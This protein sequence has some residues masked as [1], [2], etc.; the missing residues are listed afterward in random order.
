MQAKEKSGLASL[1]RP[2]LA[3]Y[4]PDKLAVAFEGLDMTADA[5]LFA[6]CTGRQRQEYACN[7]MGIRTTY[8]QLNKEIDRVARALM[9]FG[10][11]QGDYVSL[12]LPNLKESLLY[13][14]ACWRI[15]AI[16]NLIDPRTHGRGIAERVNLTKSKLLVTVMNVCDP[17]IDEVLG[18]LP[19]VVVVSPS[20]SLKPC[21]HLKATLG[22]FLFNAKKKKFAEGR[23]D[24]GK[25]VW[26]T[27]FIKKY[28]YGGDIRAQYLPGMVAAVMY[29]SGTSSDGIIKGAVHTHAGINA[30][31]RAYKCSGM[32]SEHNRGLTFGG[33]IPF[34]AAYGV[35]CGMHTSLCAGAEIILIPVFD[36]NKFADMVLKYK[37]NIFMGVP[38]FFEQIA[39]HP[40]L[41]KPN[42][43]L[44]FVR[45]PASGGDKI[46]PASLEKINQA[47]ARSGYTGGL[48]VGYGS[49]EL[50]GS[51][52]VM[53]NYQNDPN[54]D[55]KAEG[56]VGYLLPQCRA[57]VVDPET[58][59]EL[60]YGQDG[61]LCV[62]SLCMMEGYLGMPERTEEITHIGPDGTKYYRMG[63]KGHMDENGVFYF[64]D[65]YKRS[66]M[67]PDGHTV[68]PSPIENAIMSHEAV[69]NC[70]VVG[71]QQADMAGV[72][73]TAFVQLRPGFGTEAEK[74]GAL[75]KI[76][77]LCL[78][79]LPER[80]RAIAY[81]AVEELPYT[82]MGKIHFRELE[83]EAFDEEA[84]L[85]T[86]FAF[87]PDRKEK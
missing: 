72:I 15:G 64:I 31:P 25:Y 10:V 75:L 55:W 22:Y 20:D 40:K 1:D 66:I 83:K 43:K 37:P 63:D 9:G 29:T 26:H 79:L 58:M 52:S 18:D 28:N 33:F 68:H 34:F 86:D 19:T 85:I 76:D 81:K 41:Q 70:A 50:G 71:L 78:Q 54:L 32:Q 6:H 67:R 3:Q 27:D 87:F 17:K 35:F 11:R 4:D 77:G 30:M 47:F 46:S 82:P 57:M 7:F 65:R 48:R 53:Q 80:D 84:F 59:R 49:T 45:I 51:I 44:S 74:R 36:P 60:P 73:P 23:M 61:E 21:P 8:E 2:H 56:N 42:N 5:F 62:S 16:T 24:G 69:L 12:S 38:R 13:I 39:R 14:Y